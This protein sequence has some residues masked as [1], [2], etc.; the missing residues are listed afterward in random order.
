MYVECPVC[1]DLTLHTLV[2]P[3]YGGA[4]HCNDCGFVKQSKI[5]NRKDP[6]KRSWFY[7]YRHEIFVF[8]VSVITGIALACLFHNW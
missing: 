8:V 5:V 6:R 7:T 1:E 2:G 3:S 4:L